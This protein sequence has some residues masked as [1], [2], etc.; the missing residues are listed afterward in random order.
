MVPGPAYENN[1]R[2]LRI[3]RELYRPRGGIKINPPD[4]AETV[5]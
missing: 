5:R 2:N 4:P 3:L 1:Q